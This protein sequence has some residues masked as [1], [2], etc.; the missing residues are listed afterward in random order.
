MAEQFNLRL[1]ELHAYTVRKICS[2]TDEAIGSYLERAVV[3]Q[4]E[5]DVRAKMPEEWQSIRDEMEADKL[6][7]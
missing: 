3:T 4:V 2:L 7:K 5:N 6:S 1:S